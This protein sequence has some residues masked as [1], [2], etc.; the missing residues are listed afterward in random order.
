V[1]V[2]ENC[3]EVRKRFSIA[4]ELGHAQLEHSFGDAAT[5]F[6]TEH[7]VFFRCEDKDIDSDA[8]KSKRPLSEVL[9]NKFAAYV[10]MPPNLVREVWRKYQ[11]VHECADALQVSIQALNIRLS[12]LGFMT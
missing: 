12:E 4:H 1:M 5:L 10:L 3:I 2:K 6:Q 9:A 7:P 11:N 8:A